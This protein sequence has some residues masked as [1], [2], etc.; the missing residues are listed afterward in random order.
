M[1]KPEKFNKESQKLEGIIMPNSE[2]Y[3]TGIKTTINKFI[4]NEL[5]VI[6]KNESQ[7]NL[8]QSIKNKEITICAGAPGCGKT[9]IAVAL[10]LSLLKKSGNRYNKIY[11]V[12][13][14]TTLKGEELGYLKGDLVE[15]FSPFMMSYY[16]NIEKIIGEV[17]LKGLIEKDIIRPFPLAYIKGSSL[18]DCIIIGDELQNVSLNNSHVLLTRIGSNAKLIL[19]GDIKQIDIKDKHESSLEQLLVMFENSDKIGTV[20]MDK[21]DTNV[22]NPIIDMIEEKFD[23]YAEKKGK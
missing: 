8:I 15:K 1:P 5:K 10:A 20:V 12:K 9:Y 3:I 19:L 11:L 17:A 23:E 13:S 14:V 7:K 18:D 16:I 22:R 4:P 6:A 21:N 2:E